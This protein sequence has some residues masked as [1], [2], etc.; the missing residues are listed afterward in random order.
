MPSDH[1]RSLMQCSTQSEAQ[2]FSQV[3]QEW[4]HAA[5]LYFGETQ[6]KRLRRRSQNSRRCSTGDSRP[7]GCVSQG[8][9]QRAT[10]YCRHLP[11]SEHSGL[12]TCSV[13]AC[14]IPCISA[15]PENVPSVPSLE[16]AIS[17]HPVYFSFSKVWC[18]RRKCS[19][20]W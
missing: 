1:N 9:P 14:T 18:M 6:P 13:W 12:S 15:D 3:D 11:H 5:D 16:L 2:R 17:T 4:F 19:R 8:R 20:C 7:H 10:C